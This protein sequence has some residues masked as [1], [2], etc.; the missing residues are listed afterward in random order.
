MQIN[1]VSIDCTRILEQNQLSYLQKTRSKIAEQIERLCRSAG[2]QCHTAAVSRS[3][4]AMLHLPTYIESSQISHIVSTEGK[5][6]F[7]NV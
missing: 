4:A 3:W 5:K 6:R 1:L 2:Q 7:C